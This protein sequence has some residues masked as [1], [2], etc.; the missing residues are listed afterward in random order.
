MSPGVE[1]QGRKSSKMETTDGC[2]IFDGCP[3]RRIF[4]FLPPCSGR[5]HRRDYQAGG[6]VGMTV[7]VRVG[8]GG[9]GPMF[10]KSISPT[11]SDEKVR[12]FDRFGV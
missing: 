6:R 9:L 10:A 8:V 1:G 12:M 11:G 7:E 4:A 5:R 2:D 3:S